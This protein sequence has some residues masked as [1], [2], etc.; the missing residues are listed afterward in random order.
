M[1]RPCKRG[2][3]V[4]NISA[5]LFELD[6]HKTA[7]DHEIL[8]SVQEISGFLQKQ[9]HNVAPFSNQALGKF[10]TFEEPRKA[11]AVNQLSR[12]NQLLQSSMIP[13]EKELPSISEVHP[14][15]N[16]VEAALKFF[17]LKL[18]DDFWKTVEPH[19]IIEIYNDEGIQVFR[20]FNFFTN[21]SYSITD[22]LVNEWYVLWERPKF[23]L[24]KIFEYSNGILSGEM[25]GVI[26]MDIPK[27]VIK[28]ISSE[29]EALVGFTPRSTLV[30]F[31]HIC[32]LFDDKDDHDEKVK[33]I[34]V[35]SRG[36][37]NTFGAEETRKVIIF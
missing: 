5:N 16:L 10:Q 33:G 15:K 2:F 7:L 29:S 30:E 36:Y 23:V 21:S 25:K 12:L 4:Q 27:H 32:A 37:P 19:D 26:K 35:S 13:L 34:L 3:K 9:G 24:Q 11:K 31:S 8:R 28:E 22:L 18:R 20:T 6:F 14:E 1:L 17:N